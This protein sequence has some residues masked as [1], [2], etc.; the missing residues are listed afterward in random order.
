MSSRTGGQ[1]SEQ[2]FNKIKED[3]SLNLKK[4]R[5]WVFPDPDNQSLTLV[6]AVLLRHPDIFHT[7]KIFMGAGLH[8]TLS[9][10]VGLR[11]LKKKTKSKSLIDEIDGVKVK[12]VRAIL[13]IPTKTT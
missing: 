7:S 13:P 10:N 5:D 12:T 11:R 3:R 4:S 6:G 8:L 2:R 9:D 1:R